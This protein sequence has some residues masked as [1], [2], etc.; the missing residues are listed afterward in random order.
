MMELFFYLIAGHALADFALQSDDM[1]KGKNRNRRLD[2]ML[3]IPPGQKPMTVWPYWLTSHALIHGGAVALITGVWWLGL[4]EFVIHWAIDFAKCEN[5][6]GI[7]TDQALH[8]ACKLLWL[9]LLP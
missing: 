6:T 1:A 4:A 7:H 8:V 3:K 5:W 2:M 9:G